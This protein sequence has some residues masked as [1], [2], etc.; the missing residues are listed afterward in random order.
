MKPTREELE[1]IATILT[2][3]YQELHGIETEFRLMAGD[4]DFRPRIEH[5]HDGVRAYTAQTDEEQESD[6]RLS[7]EHLAQDLAALRFLQ[8]MPLAT[9]KLDPPMASPRTDP[10][11]VGDHDMLVQTKRPSRKVREQICELYQNYA[12]LYAALM[13]PIADTDYHERLD[14]LNH[15]VK[16]LH[17]LIA[18]LE[19]LMARKGGVD[20]VL[21]AIHHL[22]SDDLRHELNQF[23]AQEKYKKQENLQKL[24]LFLK[25]NVDRNDK[26][27][28]E[29]DQSHMK[30]AMAQLAIFEGS[31]DLLKKMAGKGMNLVG[32][33][34]QN[35]MS[36][37]GRDMG[38]S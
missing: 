26:D 37:S 4:N 2:R 19:A 12:V 20:A 32:R 23:M 27:I 28:D 38:R 14:N 35:A 25:A 13:K 17:R 7:V 18:A 1:S 31:R 21:T 15:D 22:E 29:I 8:T 6:K 10:V 24:I 36:E 11:A 33:F 16:D 3:I 30:F 34:V 5:F 9:L